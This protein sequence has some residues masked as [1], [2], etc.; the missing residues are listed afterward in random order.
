MKKKTKQSLLRKNHLPL[1][2]LGGAM[3]LFGLLSAVVWSISSNQAMQGL[4]SAGQQRTRLAS[5]DSGSGLVVGLIFLVLFIWCAVKS[6]GAVR[7]AFIVGAFASL[8][9]ILTGRTEGLLF[10]TLGLVLPAG[11]VIA[12]AVATFL[13]MLPMTILFIILASSGK[14]PRSCRWIAL[15]SIFLVLGSALLPIVITVFAFLIKPGD[16]G[17]GQI[18]EVGSKI[19]KLRYILPGIS[20]LFM[21]YFSTRFSK[22]H[23]DIEPAS[24]PQEGG[25]K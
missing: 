7:A 6:K 15:L 4:I 3:A 9:P 25:T 19:V 5:F 24:I 16:P 12:A 17:I 21:A 10:D 23:T 13:F 2:L 18:M 14:V 1:Y 22:S 8:G 20:F 11:S